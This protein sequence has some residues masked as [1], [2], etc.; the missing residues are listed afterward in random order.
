M[1]VPKVPG[2]FKFSP[3]KLI[4]QIVDGMKLKNGVMTIEVFIDN[5]GNVKPSE[6]G[7]RLP[8][9]QATMNHSLSYGINIYEILIDIALNN[10][11]SLNYRKPIVSVGDLYLPNKQGTIAEI[12]SL[13]EIKQYEGFVAGELFAQVGCF[14]TKRRVGNDASGWVQVMGKNE[15]ETLNRM[16]DIFNNFVIFTEEEIKEGEKKYVKKS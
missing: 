11:V 16:Q 4:Q 13:E 12:T 1:T 2:Y 15:N 3:K 6:L 7:W 14:Q 8:G 10:H 9:C 5:F